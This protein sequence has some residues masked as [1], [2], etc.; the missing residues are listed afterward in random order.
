MNI[1]RRRGTSTCAWAARP[2]AGFLAGLAALLV[3]ASCTSAPRASPPDP[4]GLPASDE[5]PVLLDT[6]RLTLPVDA[7]LLA[8]SE[9]RQRSMARREL[10]H[11]CL[12]RFGIAV[13]IPE[14]PTEVGPRTRNE[15][16]YGLTDAAAAATTGYGLG[17]RDP[18][19]RGGGREDAPTLTARA[20]AVLTGHGSAL[21]ARVPEGGC[22]GEVTRLLTPVDPVTRK[23]LNEDLP[24]ALSFASFSTSQS[25]PRVQA[26]FG[27]WASCMRKQ[28]HSYAAPLEPPADPRFGNPG[29]AAERATAEADVACKAQTNLVGRWYA[30][31]SAE[32]ARLIEEH[33]SELESLRAAELEVSRFV[34]SIS[35]S[36]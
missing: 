7:H 16:R 26:A 27:D 20:R 11:D 1:H 12:L 4:A 36:R 30:V 9:E 2:L 14:P 19:T 8:L 32:Q 3:L 24:E 21:P 6:T 34:R 29:G 31:E 10:L 17:D 33:Q 15:R 28:G 13:V 23:S 35:T 18:R 25:D 5:V 22:S